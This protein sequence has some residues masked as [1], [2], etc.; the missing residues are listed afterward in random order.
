VEGRAV[1]RFTKAGKEA[2]IELVGDQAFE[3][4]LIGVTAADALVGKDMVDAMTQKVGTP[5][6]V[7]LED[8][9]PAITNAIDD[10]DC[11]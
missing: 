11:I 3:K 10:F 4:K 9:R 7:G 6:V 2:L 8:S 5:T 1:R